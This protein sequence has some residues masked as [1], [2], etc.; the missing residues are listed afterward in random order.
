VPIR[1][2]RG[3]GAYRTRDFAPQSLRPRGGSLPRRCGARTV[4]KGFSGVKGASGPAARSGVQNTVGPRTP[5]TGPILHA[6]AAADD[7]HDQRACAPT[8]CG[9]RTFDS[10]SCIQIFAGTRD[11]DPE[12]PRRDE[13]L[14]KM[15]REARGPRRWQLVRPT[16]GGGRPGAAA[17]CAGSSVRVLR[18][19]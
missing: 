2:R 8:F 6:D 12:S 1:I 5:S 4:R 19:S 3:R 9:T 7:D 17:A 18:T 11:G 15:L 13:L 10:A 16:G 14:G